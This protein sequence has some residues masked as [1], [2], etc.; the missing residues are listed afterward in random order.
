MTTAD[1]LHDAV[2]AG[3]PVITPQRGAAPPVDATEVLDRIDTTLDLI[4]EATASAEDLGPLER[5]DV[6]VLVPARNRRDELP[7]VLDRLDEVMPPATEVIVIDAAST[8]GTP[9]YVRGRIRQ[10][11]NA[12]GRSG[13]ERLRLLGRRVDHGR[14]SDLRLGIRHSRGHVV[15][16]QDVDLS[17]DPADLL[18]GVWPILERKA[19]AVFGMRRERGHILDKIATRITN[20]VAGVDLHDTLHGQKVFR[21]KVLR[22]L[23]L[24]ETGVGFDAEAT[25]KFVAA[26]DTHPDAVGMLMQCPMPHAIDTDVLSDRRGTRTSDWSD[27]IG[28][29]RSAWRHR[30]LDRGVD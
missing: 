8:D 24:T 15:A 20:H 1:S 19:D 14:G 11:A 26:L 29:I 4:A 21:G 16:I 3:P 5:V 30:G 6:T 18:A 25:A 22:S 13:A 27:R 7:V 9:Q 17:Q 12:T 23:A 2:L 28:M 10:N